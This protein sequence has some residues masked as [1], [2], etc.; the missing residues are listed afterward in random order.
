[1]SRRALSR[2]VP[3]IAGGVIGVTLVA[4]VLPLPKLL[5]WNASASAPIGLYRVNPFARPAIGDMVAVAPPPALARFMAE[6]HY[7]PV[8]VPLLKHVAAH[9]GALICRGDGAVTIDG[10]TVAVARASDSH[11]R[12][13]PV[14]RGCRVLR[15]DELFLLNAAQDSLDGRYFGPIPASGLIGRASPL[16]TRDTPAAPLRWRSIHAGNALPTSNEGAV[17]CR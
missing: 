4:A 2:F 8:G 16:L 12:P 15:T 11:G 13:L 5:L 1:M 6:R 10:R 9:P 7:L 14:W 3:H 17:S